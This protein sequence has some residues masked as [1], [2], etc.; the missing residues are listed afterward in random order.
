MLTAVRDI[1]ELVDQRVLI[2]NEGGSKNTSCS[3]PDE[4]GPSS[5]ASPPSNRHRIPL[6]GQRSEILYGCSSIRH[7]C[8]CARESAK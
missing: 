8:C 7:A 6:S 1:K 4:A 5:F 3:I 2:R